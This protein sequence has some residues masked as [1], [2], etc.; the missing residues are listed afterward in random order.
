MDGPMS[1]ESGAL[2]S[3]R[4]AVLQKPKIALV[5][6][7]ENWAFHNIAKQLQRRLSN[8]YDFTIFSAFD[9]GPLHRLLLLTQKFDLVHFFWRL[10]L[11]QLLDDTT[12]KSLEAL[13]INPQVFLS[14]YRRRHVITSAVFDHL[15]LDQPLMLERVSHAFRDLRVAY[16]VSSNKLD[17]LYIDLADFN[18]PS[19]VLTDGVDLER[20]RPERLDR[21]AVQST[22]KLSI[23]WVGNSKWSADV[24]DFKGVHTILRPAIQELIEEGLPIE[25]KLADRQA[26]FIPNEEMP[27]FY[28]GLDVYVCVS[29]IE[30]TPNPVLEAMSCGVPVVSTDVGV[31]RDAFGPL[32]SEFILEERSIS[33]LKATLKRLLAQR[34]LLARL[35]AE[36]LISIKQWSWSYKATA[37]AR[38]FDLGLKSHRDSALKSAEV[39]TQSSTDMPSALVKSMNVVGPVPVEAAWLRENT[40][41]CMLFFNKLEQTIESAETFL[42][43]GVRLNL[44]DNGSAPA[45][46]AQMREHFAGNPRVRVVDAQRNRGVSGGRNMQLSETKEPWLLFVDNDIT[47]ETTDWVERMAEAIN[48]CP[49]AQIFAPRLFNK[50]EDSWGSMSDFVVDQAGNCAFVATQAEFSNAFPGGA[51]L[52]SRRVFEEFGGYDEDLFV[53][54]EDFE[55]AIRAWRQ[56]RPLLVRHVEDVVLI[57]DHRVSVAAAD[58]QTAMVRYDQ[59]HIGHSHGVVHAKHGVLLDPNFGAWLREQVRQ[60]T[61]ETV[62]DTKVEAIPDHILRGATVRPRRCAEGV[63]MQV[64]VDGGATDVWSTLRSLQLAR[65]RAIECGIHVEVHVAEMAPALLCDAVAQGL[66]QAAFDGLTLACSDDSDSTPIILWVGG[67]LVSSDFLLQ[68]AQVVT[69][70]PGADCRVFHPGRVVLASPDGR[71]VQLE[72]VTMFDPFLLEHSATQ[73]PVFAMHARLVQRFAATDE[74]WT[75][76]SALGLL[77]RASAA[78]FESWGVPD[79]LVVLRLAPEQAVEQ[80]RRMT[81]GQ[82]LG[83]PVRS[84]AVWVHLEQEN[85]SDVALNLDLASYDWNNLP[86]IQQSA[87]A[88]LV[89]PVLQLLPSLL[90]DEVTHV[91]LAP[92]LKRGGSDRATLAYLQALARHIPGR[93]LLITTEG[94]DSAWNAKVPKDVRLIE[95]ANVAA[96][97][98]ADQARRNLA[99]MLARLSPSAVHVMNSWLGWELLAN[100]GPRLNAVA[101]T[102]ASLFWY[103]PS[104]RGKLHGYASEYAPRVAAAGAIDA[105]LTDNETFPRRLLKDYGIPARLFSCVRHPTGRIAGEVMYR[106][107]SAVNPS[108]FGLAAL[109]RKSAWICCLALPRVGRT[110]ALWCLDQTMEVIQNL[111]RR[112]RL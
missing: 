87:D 25:L 82:C 107:T 58:K 77:S 1:K 42:H 35:S 46:A 89:A 10:H 18:S 97:N 86:V 67:G 80:T 57:H 59:G 12:S 50:H 30:G 76:G 98:T 68:T 9:I 7:A 92:W 21:F 79:S 2:G 15:F 24:E 73:L 62:A 56:K 64:I 111:L 34:D 38:F 36:N 100:E 101:H 45:A 44:L 61:G 49:Q 110:I 71:G 72:H 60:L 70:S 52:I 88:F 11:V 83:K 84:H 66:A 32:Q 23:G 16:S 13:G 96:W 90:A 78:G 65:G 102:F 95:W 17:Q 55:L 48:A 103:G 33:A 4:P 105:Y 93:V 54:F 27:K 94:S 26:G 31:V 8:Q 81:E 14:E 104:Q 112:S 51:S 108:F 63:V 39:T 75:S 91:L 6:D 74:K 22:R 109:H 41:V 43:A 47:V 40:V 99:W 69:F 20:F 53:G 3:K 5:V 28:A 29:K 37:Y 106:N 19:A 85:L